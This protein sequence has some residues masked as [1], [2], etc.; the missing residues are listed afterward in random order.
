MGKK[1]YLVSVITPF[2]NTKMEF[3]K[4]G[5]ESLTRQTLGFKNIEWV[6]VIHNS[7]SSYVDMVQKLVQKDDNVKVYILNNNEKTPSSPRNYALK[8]AQGKYIAFLDSDDFFTDDGLREVVEGME[9]TGA[10]I[11]SFRAETLPEDETV[12]QAIDT[13]ARF[14]QT[15]HLLEM[16]KGDEKLNDLIY[17]G[18]L[19]I[20]SKLTRRDFLNKYKISFSLDIKYGEDVCFSMECMGKAKKIIILPQ[21]IVYVYFMNHGSIAQDM[22]HTRESL[23]KLASDFARIFDVTIKGG[24][25]LEKLA[26][27]VLGYLAEM[28]AIT[29]GLDDEFRKSIYNL[30]NKYFDILGPLE[31]DA[32]FFNEQMAEHFMKRARMIILGEEEDDEMDKSPLPPILLA[33]AD[34]E[35]GRKYG[36]GNIRSIKEYQKKVPLTD[37]NTYRP[38]VKLMTHIGESNLICKEKVVAYSKKICPDGGEFLIPQTASFASIYQNRLSEEL[39]AAK[40]STFLSM[41]SVGESGT[42]RFNDGAILRSIADTVLSNIRKTDIYNSHT[43]SAE[44]K[45]GT[46]TSP[47]SVVFKNPGEDM[48]YAKILFALADPD[49]SQVIVPFTVDL[50]DILRFL[51]CMWE[52]LVNDLASGRISEASGLSENRR[53]E[54]SKLLKTSKRRAKELTSI[55]EQGFEDVLPKIWKKLDLIIAAGSGE[56]AVYTRQIMKYIGSVPLNYGY[57]GLAEGI[58][59]KVSAP[60]EN[61][62]IVMENDSF[63]EFLPENSTKDNTLTASELEISKHYEVIISNM[64]GLY[65]YR[66]GIIVEAAKIQ[67]GQAFVRYCYDTKDVL[68]LNGAGINPLS[69]RQAGKKIDEEAGMITY[70]YCLFTNEKKNRFEL[71]LMPE[72][73]G[74]Y[75][76]K[77]VQDIAEKELLKTIPSYAKARKENKIEKI[78][79]HF[80]P[81]EEAYIVKGKAPMPIRTIHTSSNEELLKYFKTQEI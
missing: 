59:G 58:V 67:D 51:Q 76:A 75:S 46:I 36:F 16:K 38:L 28:I 26:W 22:N 66:S 49:V 68:T 57:L 56:N 80:L 62:Y 37:Y 13:R 45:Y 12:I 9:E 25:K 8:K 10:D 6:V 30:M 63:I 50:L 72:K 19:T 32:K 34:T 17:A 5:Y 20:W 74:K 23:F 65:R 47:E 7:D 41:E 1:E 21:T 15:A 33:N 52:P 78:G 39:K 31:P 77:H 73:K 24:Y 79:I 35:Y 18:G 11:A 69:L 53:K 60:G 64:A 40:Y 4:R 55:F 29:P 54:L 3:F 27:P 70:D 2:H 44:N 48:R 43:R 14:D 61:T 71:F 81:S 42:I